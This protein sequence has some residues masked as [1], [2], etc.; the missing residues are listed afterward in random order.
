MGI[1]FT[2]LNVAS[3]I[4]AKAGIA[5]CGTAIAPLSLSPLTLAYIGDCV[6]ELIVRT[7]VVGTAERTVNT[8]H[9]HTCRYVN[10]ATQHAMLERLSAQ[11]TEEEQSV[12]RRGRNAKSHS[13]A[14]HASVSDYRHATGFEAL[15][16]YW[17][18]SGQ[19]DRMLTLIAEA[20]KA[21]LSESFR[22]SRPK[23]TVNSQPSST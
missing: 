13:V 16:G 5:D 20:M 18:L 10:A 19:N 3:A 14:K 1:D 11:L 8:I 12:V 21:C 6:Y 23:I 22:N 17:Y 15:C 4:L 9:K 7:I 2:E